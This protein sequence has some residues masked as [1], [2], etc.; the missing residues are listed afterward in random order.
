MNIV[1][2]LLSIGRPSR[3]TYRKQKLEGD[4]Q[5][6]NFGKSIKRCADRGTVP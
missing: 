3:T 1:K 5:K 2:N 4:E 6:P